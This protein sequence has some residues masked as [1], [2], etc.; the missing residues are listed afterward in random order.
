[1]SV[2][3]PGGRTIFPQEP[4][5]DPDES[6]FYGPVRPV[7]LWP[8]THM[9][10]TRFSWGTKFI[11]VRSDSAKAS[12]EKIGLYCSAGWGAFHAANG[13]LLLK[14]INTQGLLSED[15]P[16]M[17][18]NFEVYTAGG[19]QEF[20]SLGP[21]DLLDPGEITE[22]TEHWVLMRKPDLPADDDGLAGVLPAIVEEAEQLIGE[23]F[24]GE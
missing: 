21:L 11:Q 3:A 2:V 12:A 17:G 15:Y 24:P 1:L 14:F 4:F 23:A 8:Y 13:D 16:D 22:H 20:E 10:D 7:V 19:F 18:C 9:G 6:G 5:L